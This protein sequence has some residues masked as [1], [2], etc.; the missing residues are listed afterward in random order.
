MFTFIISPNILKIVYHLCNLCYFNS[1][2][3][4]A[5]VKDDDKKKTPKVK[6]QKS[7]MESRYYITFTIIKHTFTLDSLHTDYM[8]C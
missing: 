3:K 8:T 4:K 6:T 7:R 1:K 2:K 5:V